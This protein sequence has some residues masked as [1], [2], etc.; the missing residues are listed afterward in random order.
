MS[1]PPDIHPAAK[2]AGSLPLA[3]S[4]PK[5]VGVKKPESPRRLPEFLSQRTL[6]S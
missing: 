6:R 4:V 3:I 2:F 1:D 5:P